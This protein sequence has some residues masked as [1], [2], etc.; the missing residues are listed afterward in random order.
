MGG[1]MELGEVGGDSFEYLQWPNQ[2]QLR[3]S[4]PKGI[5]RAFFKGQRWGKQGALTI[6][7]ENPVITGR[8]QMK[9]FIP[10]EIFRQKK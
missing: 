3:L 1:N 7:M 8:I 4:L 9:W 6:C 5:S 10:V 2:L